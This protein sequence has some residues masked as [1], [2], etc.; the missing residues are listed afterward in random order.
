MPDPN[1]QDQILAGLQ[2]FT[3]LAWLGCALSA[4]VGY[5]AFRQSADLYWLVAFAVL[6]AAY[7]GEALTTYRW[8]GHMGP[9]SD[10]MR[11]AAELNTYYRLRL[12]ALELAAALLIFHLFRQRRASY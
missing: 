3:F 1:A 9:V 12:G 11:Q 10:T 8:I 7:L 6:A 5:R 2:L 4:W